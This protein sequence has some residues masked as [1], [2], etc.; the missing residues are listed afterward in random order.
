MDP[1][2]QEADQK[3]MEANDAEVAAESLKDEGFN[4]N[5]K[6]LEKKAQELKEQAEQQKIDTE[7]QITEGN[8]YSNT[9]S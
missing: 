2:E 8:F 6:V 1:N 4:E 7:S 9:S 3:L 5:S